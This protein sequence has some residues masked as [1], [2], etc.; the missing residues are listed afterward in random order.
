VQ[1]GTSST[2][3]YCFR[4][5]NGNITQVQTPGMSSPL[6]HFDYSPF[7]Q[8]LDASGALVG[9]FPFGFSSK[10]LDSEVGLY[11]Y[12]YG[13]YAPRLGRWLNRDPI[14]EQGGLNL[15]AFVGNEPV[16][17]SDVCGLWSGTYNC[18]YTNYGCNSGWL[19]SYSKC[20]MS[21]TLVECDC[22]TCPLTLSKIWNNKNL[23]STCPGC[24]AFKKKGA[25][26]CDSTAAG[27]WRCAPGN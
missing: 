7:G 18:S 6:A 8:K 9:I 19:Y 27:G 25:Y 11:Y 3:Y 26:G 15:Y 13:H 23:G 1:L 2:Q 20:G 10:Y 21:C 16:A 17:N 24:P 22:P 5:G 14:A 12:G 4:D